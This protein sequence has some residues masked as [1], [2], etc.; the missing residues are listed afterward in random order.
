M[1]VSS[2]SIQ[3]NR[4]IT[5]LG[6]LIAPAT[7]LAA[8]L[9]VWQ[10]LATF[11]QVPVYLLPKP[12]DFLPKLGSDYS[13]ILWHTG[14]TASIILFGFV[15]SAAIAVPLAFLIASNRSVE[16]GL[17]PLIVCLELVPKTITAPLLIVWFGIGPVPRVALTVLMTFFAI[18]V[19]SLSGFK[20]VDPRLYHLSR[21]MGASAWQTFWYIRLPAAMPFI[22]AGFKIGIVNA[23]TATIVAEFIGSSVGLGFLILSASS[24]MNMPLMFNGIVTVAVLGVVFNLIVTS[25]ESRLMPWSIRSGKP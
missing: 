8:I 16:K 21:S 13:L 11:Y 15:S 25:L 1:S 20:A 14:A 6:Q 5:S 19:E 9:I 10:A 2:T 12:T 24:S 23:V 4:L 22:F 17:Y 7:T 3:R 18:L